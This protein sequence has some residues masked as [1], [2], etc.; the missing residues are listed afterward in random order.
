MEKV[1]F[2]YKGRRFSVSV[3]NC[4]FFGKIFGLMFKKKEN[5]D[6]LLFKFTNPGK[7]SI[8]SLFVFFP[9][10]AVWLDKKG[11]VVNVKKIKPFTLSVSPGK[12]FNKLI[13]IPINRKYRGNVNKLLRYSVG[14][15]K[16]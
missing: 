8:H 15:R 2:R 6:G 7:I 4:G 9:F 13:E 12:K 11:R 3:R 10:V 1:S 16:I 14:V 5:A